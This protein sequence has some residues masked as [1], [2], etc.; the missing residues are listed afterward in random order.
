MKSLVLLL[1][2]FLALTVHGDNNKKPFGPLARQ[3]ATISKTGYSVRVQNGTPQLFEG[4][5]PISSTG[6]MY[7]Q[8]NPEQ[9]KQ[10]AKAGVHL[11][12][13]ECRHMGWIGNDKYDF[14]LID[15][16]M[17]ELFECD[18]QA[19]V[20]PFFYVGMDPA[21]V[22]PEGDWWQ[23]EHRDDLCIDEHGKVFSRGGHE[24]VSFASEAWRRDAGKAME[25]FIQHME[26]SPYGGQIVG[27]QPCAGGSYEWMYHGGQKSLFFDY[28]TPTVKAFHT[29]LGKK[30]Q[31]SEKKLRA[32]WKDKTVTFETAS[33][34]LQARRQHASLGQLRDPALEAPVIDYYVFL[35]ELTADT[36]DCFC[37][38]VK[39]ATNGRKIAGA[40]YGYVLEQMVGGYSTQ[41]T[42]H[43]ALGKLLRSNHVDFVMSPTSYWNRQPGGAG[44]L[45]TAMASVRLHKKLWIN[46]ADIR[47]H[48][49]DKASRFGR[50]DTEAQSVGVMRREFAMDLTAGI[51]VYWYSFSLP[52]FGPSEALMANIQQMANI[53]AEANRRDRRLKGDKLAVIVSDSPAAYLGLATEPLRSLVYLQ[54]ENLLRS[55]VPFDVYLDSDLDNPD[56]PKYKA[57]LLL[58]SIHLTDR[59][60][61]HIDALKNDG[62]VLAWVWAQGIADDT[63]SVANASSLCGIHLALSTDAGVATITPQDGYGPAYGSESKFAPMVYPDDA[64][65]QTLG[66]LLSPASLAGKPGLAIK[67]NADWTTIYSASPRLSPEMIRA[68]ARLAG[69]HVYANGNDPI[70]ISH[71]YIGIHATGTGPKTITLPGPAKIIDCFTGK[72]VAENAPVFSVNMEANSTGIYRLVW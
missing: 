1:T 27:Y 55:G 42:G 25:K 68:I 7:E 11:Y 41:H 44:G 39:R 32:A 53:D 3:Q 36:I 50:C 29:W 57:Y 47:T 71:E 69:V 16:L 48:L 5:R 24:T 9:V 13:L 2:A 19:R 15:G 38:M 60:R 14:A 4:D 56:M 8:P 66:T 70:Y 35:S 31:D 63:L 33:I 22:G 21:L 64:S 54:R 72:S 58:D 52:W 46:Q 65:T 34:P 10:F 49:S 51:P 67:K 40:F 30:Y 17:A 26:K 45:M 43:F 18:P 20:I 59:I 62:R 37:G 23:N 61:H 12:F 28:S 6:F